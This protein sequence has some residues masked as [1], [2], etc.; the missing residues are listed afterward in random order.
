MSDLFG[1]RYVAL[2][3]ATILIVGVIVMSTAK[4]MNIFI[5]GSVLCGAGAAINELTAVSDACKIP[6][7]ISNTHP[8]PLHAFAV[9]NTQICS[10]HDCTDF[11]IACCNR[12]TCSYA[13]AWYLRVGTHTHDCTIYAISTLCTVD[14]KP[15]QLAMGR[16]ILCTLGFCRPRCYCILLLPTSSSQLVRPYTARDFASD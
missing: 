14:R 4:N 12:R 7:S 15:H 6:V 9:P 10:F 3:G 11:F 16:P 5:C 2:T 1:R 13:Q 8:I